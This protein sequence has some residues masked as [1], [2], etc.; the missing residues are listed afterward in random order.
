MDLMQKG[1]QHAQAGRFEEALDAF[2]LALENDKE[3]PDLHF[4]LGLSF[5]SL[6]QFEYAK[7][8]YE[9]ALMLDPN[10]QKTKLV[11]DSVQNVDAKTPPER[12]MLLKAVA[13]TRKEQEGGQTEDN[14]K[15][16]SVEPD[17]ASY[18]EPSTDEP[19]I[20][21]TDD[22]WEQAFPAG[23]LK[24]R[25]KSPTQSSVWMRLVWTLIGI[26]AV[27]AA[28]YY[29]LNYFYPPIVQSVIQ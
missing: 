7:H 4:Y 14:A 19:R 24:P 27:G 2:L 15:P 6:E 29:A 28:V 3:N 8:H 26:A 13:K 20:K 5:S 21:L 25:R 22:K 10:H 11:F 1:K 12:K 9:T 17:N 18:D 23:N 16:Q